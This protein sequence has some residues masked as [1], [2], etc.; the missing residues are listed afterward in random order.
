MSFFQWTYMYNR[1]VI[2][3]VDFQS[4]FY[5]FCI[6]RENVTSF[7]LF[8]LASEEKSYHKSKKGNLCSKSRTKLS[9]IFNNRSKALIYDKLLVNSCRCIWLT[10][11]ISHFNLSMR[12]LSANGPENIKQA[13]KIS[14]NKLLIT[15]AS[16]CTK[17]YHSWFGESHG[18]RW[19]EV[20]PHGLETLNYILYQLI[21]GLT[22]CL[23]SMLAIWIPDFL[24]SP[25]LYL[26]I[27]LTQRPSTSRTL[28][29]LS[30]KTVEQRFRNPSVQCQNRR[31]T[32]LHI[33][34]PYL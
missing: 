19:Y 10:L 15:D 30:A 25:T 27:M 14:R 3:I 31:T 9:S 12:C 17:C 6:V 29:P 20:Y 4:N 5:S 26:T 23:L 28:N 7:L 21:S 2:S 33:S 8:W 1:W 13:N 11:V 18:M 22:W 32:F 34:S 16:K 24:A